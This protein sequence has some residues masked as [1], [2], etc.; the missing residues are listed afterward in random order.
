M[1]NAYFAPAPYAKQPDNFQ[2]SLEW[3]R[4]N[5]VAFEEHIRATN[6][7]AYQQALQIRNSAN[8]RAIVA[9][10]ARSRGLNPNILRMF[11]LM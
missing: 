2:Q 5:P 11:G 9:Q 1:D 7:Q 3:A 8:P 4:Q 10:M 6:P